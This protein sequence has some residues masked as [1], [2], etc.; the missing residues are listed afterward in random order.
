VVRVKRTQE[1]AYFIAMELTFA[2]KGATETL[3]L[4]GKFAEAERIQ[5]VVNLRESIEWMN[6]VI[7]EGSRAPGVGA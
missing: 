6:R 4:G 5:R 1:L 2:L 3:E 7:S